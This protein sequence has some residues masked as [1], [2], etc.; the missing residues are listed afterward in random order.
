LNLAHTHNI[1]SIAISLGGEV[2]GRDSVRV[3]G[4]GH[5]RKDRSL[6]VRFS[7]D[8]TFVT[9]SE[10]GDD[11]RS[12]NDYVRDRLGLP[13]DWR[14]EPTDYAPRIILREQEDAD[15]IA[16]RIRSALKRWETAVPIAG[17]LAETYLASRG[18]SYSGDALRFR[19]ND[20]SMVALMS[21]IATGELCGVHVTSLDAD[22]RK[23]GRKMYGKAKSAVVRLSPDDDVSNTIGIGE[24]IETCLATGFTPIWACLS[25]G[26]IRDFPVLEDFYSLHIFAD[27]DAS[28]TGQ[29][30]AN[31]CGR[32]WHTTDREVV[33]RIPVEIGVD[34]AT[35]KEVA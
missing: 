3:P 2:A 24:G 16:S 7:P 25:A 27:N 32:R 17:T 26:G 10:A 29:R 35:I 22:G 21:D 9:F 19:T 28:G 6:R 34:F 33:I 30:A 23:V 14:R 12:C 8:G 13:N 11:W 18:L 20:R 31:E 15:E 1:R 4:P 5:S